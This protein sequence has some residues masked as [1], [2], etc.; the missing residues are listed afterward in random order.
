M[1]DDPILYRERSLWPEWVNVLLWATMVAVVYP[2]LAGWGSDSDFEERLLTAVVIVMVYGAITIF[3]GGTT[4][5]VKR[6][7]L[8]VHLGFVPLIRKRVVFKD[9]ASMESVRYHPI[10]EFGGW[11]VRGFG[12]KQAWTA[13]GDQ[14]VVLHLVNGRQLYV[15]S[16]TPQRLEQW[17]RSTAGDELGQ[18]A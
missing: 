4:V 7:E 13:R 14:A 3:L 11:G 15:G 17:I 12:A 10:R 1:R 2:L 18:N 5:L 9:I 8:H 6:T 16:D